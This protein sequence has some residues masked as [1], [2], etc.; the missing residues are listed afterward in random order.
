[1]FE[2]LAMSP[3]TS[4]ILSLWKVL[5]A[6]RALQDA[7]GTLP[8]G[9]PDCLPESCPIWPQVGVSRVPGTFSIPASRLQGQ[10]PAPIVTPPGLAMLPVNSWIIRSDK[11]QLYEPC[12]PSP[13]ARALGKIYDV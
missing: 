12:T 1:M 13:N 6:P 7:I 11:D 9:Q 2:F 3:L 8:S 5:G 10:C 4:P